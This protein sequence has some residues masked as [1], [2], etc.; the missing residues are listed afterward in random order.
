[1]IEAVEK[2]YHANHGSPSGHH[3]ARKNVLESSLSHGTI[4]RFSP[5]VRT[6]APGSSFGPSRGPIDSREGEEEFLRG[7]GSFVVLGK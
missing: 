5:P 3:S 4:T 6:G 1:M 7:E 2:G